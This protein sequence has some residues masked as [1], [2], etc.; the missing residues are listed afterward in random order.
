MAKLAETRKAEW[1][2]VM[3]NA[4]Y[5]ATVAVLN[6]HGFD[7]LRMDRV[8]KKAEVATGTLYNYFKNKAEL[9][10]HV[11]DTRFKPINHDFLEI[12]KSAISPEEK[13]R[14]FVRIFLNSI[15]KYRSLMI[16][17]TTAE[18][19]SLPIKAAVDEKR[20]IGQKLL[21]DVIKEGIAQGKFRHVNPMQTARLIFG[22]LYGII[23]PMLD[24]NEEIRNDDSDLSDCMTFF[25]SGLFKIQ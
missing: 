4:I 8:A 25:S 13:L 3:K 16:I 11:I 22:A 19:L 18:S 15:K 2:L 21:A 12:L 24:T 23:Q 10:R 1:D 7:G 5:E 9:L 6:Q 17:V 20:E 14:N